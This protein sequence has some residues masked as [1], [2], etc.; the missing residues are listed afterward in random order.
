[1]HLELVGSIPRIRY[2]ENDIS[3]DAKTWIT[4]H[5]ITHERQVCEELWVSM[6]EVVFPQCLEITLR[7]DRLIEIVKDANAGMG[8]HSWI[9]GL[10]PGSTAIIMA[11]NVVLD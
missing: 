7:C 9:G 11:I 2:C 3:K 5:A 8:K 6:L 4:H 10:E 1:M